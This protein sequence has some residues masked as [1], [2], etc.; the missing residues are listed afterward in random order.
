MKFKFHFNISTNSSD[1]KLS[2]D[3]T[4][5][6]QQNFSI[7]FQNSEIYFEKKYNFS[8]VTKEIMNQKLE[9]GTAFLS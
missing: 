3:Y 4:K 8:K 1:I 7:E 6:S 2:R 9:R 5:R